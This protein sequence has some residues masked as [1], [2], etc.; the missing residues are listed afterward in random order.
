MVGGILTLLM[1]V[2]FFVMM[3]QPAFWVYGARITSGSLPSVYQCINFN[4]RNVWLV[5]SSVLIIIAMV[6]AVILLGMVIW[7]MVARAGEKRAFGTK[8]I[9]ILFLSFI[10]VAAII[11]VII[12]KDLFHVTGSGTISVGWGML[13]FVGVALLSILFAP[14][15]KNKVQPETKKRKK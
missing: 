12:A 1:I 10:A 4:S 3:T 11:Y 13:A 14:M 15:K 9:A 6:F 7:N 2:G 8:I 5:I